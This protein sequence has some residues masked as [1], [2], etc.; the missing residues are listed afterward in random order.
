MNDVS[1]LFLADVSVNTSGNGISMIRH[2]G[3]WSPPSLKRQVP[4]IS[5]TVR[6][7]VRAGRDALADRSLNKTVACRFQGE[8]W[9]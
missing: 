2:G 5:V 7:S 4:K 1:L 6:K 8:R 3:K 9:G